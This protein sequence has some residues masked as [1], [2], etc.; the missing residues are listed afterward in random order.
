MARTVVVGV[1]PENLLLCLLSRKQLSCLA[2]IRAG[3]ADGDKTE[4]TFI[5]L[6]NA[7][8]VAVFAEADAQVAFLVT[9][10]LASAIIT[11]DSDILVRKGMW[12]IGGG[13]RDRSQGESINTKH[14]QGMSQHEGLLLQSMRNR[15]HFGYLNGDGCPES[16]NTK[17]V[18]MAAVKSTASV[19]YKIDE[20][21]RCKELGFDPQKLSSLPGT[22]P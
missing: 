16:P 22:W 1:F 7:F 2:E 17:Q 13:T 3:Y 15:N 19:L 20:F 8:D 9:C 18:Y 14:Q 6:L 5:A 10:G 11:E 21:G 12:Y 4:A